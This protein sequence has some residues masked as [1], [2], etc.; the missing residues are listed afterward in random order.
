MKNHILALLLSLMAF[1][2]TG[3][4]DSNDIG[5]QISG[6]QGNPV[7]PGPNPT[8]TPSGDAFLRVASLASVQSNVDVLIN[9]TAVL[10]N[11]G[12]AEATEYREVEAGSVRIQ[13]RATGTT[14]DLLDATRTVTADTYNT[15]AVIGSSEPILGA[16]QSN[17]P[18]EV[19]GLRLLALVDDITPNNSGVSVRFVNALPVTYDGDEGASLTTPENTLLAGPVTY[20]AASLYEDFNAALEFDSVRVELGPDE[21]EF[22]T[23]EGTNQNIFDTLADALNQQP[24][25]LSVFFAYEPSLGPV[26]LVLIDRASSASEV[27]VFTEGQD[28]N[29]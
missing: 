24:G 28:Q 13:V 20:G 25:N 9:G 5:G 12:I 10:T 1:G 17:V 21:F 7:A 2:L 8:P 3:C 4:G 23:E 29:T 18:T 19:L 14:E 11:V 16:A 22:E 15:F 27:Y 6:Q 26:G